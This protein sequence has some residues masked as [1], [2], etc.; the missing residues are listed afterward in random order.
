MEYYRTVGEFEKQES[1]MIIWPHNAYATSTL[2]NDIV[3]VQIVKAIIDEVKVMICCY[4]V[5]VQKRAQEVLTSSEVDVN[6]IEF[7]IFPSP[8]IYPRDFGAEIMNK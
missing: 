4:D 2:N 1:V 8:I 3:S 7:V 5:H 6:L